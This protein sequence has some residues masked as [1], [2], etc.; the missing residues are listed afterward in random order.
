MYDEEG[1]GDLVC[2]WIQEKMNREIWE[3]LLLPQEKRD[4]LDGYA[5][6][7]KASGVTR[8]LPSF[9]AHGLPSQ[10]D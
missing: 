6:L 8:L 1:K 10:G 3:L 4:A 9:F 2:V 5:T 7:S